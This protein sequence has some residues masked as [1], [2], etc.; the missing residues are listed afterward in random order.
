MSAALVL[1]CCCGVAV[2]GRAQRWMNG[3]SDGKGFLNS[4]AKRLRQKRPVQMASLPVPRHWYG[5]SKAVY[6][7][8]VAMGV[9]VG[10]TA[11]GEC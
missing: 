1:T 6:A 9:Y 10:S 8:R 2:S 7:L 11:S 3:R 4:G 5:P